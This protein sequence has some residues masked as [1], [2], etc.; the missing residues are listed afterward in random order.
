MVSKR[1]LPI[2]L[3]LLWAGYAFAITCPAGGFLNA[4]NPAACSTPAG[5]AGPTGPTGSTGPTGA[6]GTAGVAGPTGTAGPAGP[7]GATGPTGPTGPNTGNSFWTG[8][9]PTT[10][11]NSTQ[12]IAFGEIATAT[13]IGAEA[14]AQSK[15]AGACTIS[16]LY[17]SFATTSNSSHEPVFTVDD[18]TSSTGITCTPSGAATSCSDTTHSTTTSAGDLLNVVVANPASANATGIVKVSFKITC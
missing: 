12:Y 15:I 18:N 10:G 14:T 17:V 3:V 11:A 16:N 5:G 2:A 1:L 4:I 8:A 7:T 9:S 6:T 13:A